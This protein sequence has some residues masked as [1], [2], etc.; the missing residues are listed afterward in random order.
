[1]SCNRD[2]MG[3]TWNKLSSGLLTLLFYVTLES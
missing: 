2:S 3:S 1:M